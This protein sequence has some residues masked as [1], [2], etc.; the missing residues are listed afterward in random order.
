[1]NTNGLKSIFK[2]ELYHGWNKSKRFFEGWYYKLISKNGKHQLAIIVG[3]SINDKGEK[4]AFIQLLNGERLQTSY[5]TYPF[6]KFKASTKKHEVS[7]DKSTF[8]LDTLEI[9]TKYWQGKLSFFNGKEL[10][11]K[12]Y[13]PGIM[14][15]FSFFPRME[16][17]HG[18][19]QLDGEIEGKIQFKNEVFDFS[20]G[21]VYI[22]K[23][24]GHSF[25]EAYVWCQCNNFEV[26]GTFLSLS[27][28]NVKYLGIKTM[29]FFCI[30]QYQSKQ[31][32]FSTQNISKI[33][34]IRFDNNNLTI[35]IDAQKFILFLEIHE[36]NYAKLK[37][38]SKGEMLQNIKES[39]TAKVKMNLID[40]KT[41]KTIFETKGK[42]GGL[43][44]SNP[45]LLRKSYSK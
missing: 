11:S 13:A 15:I 32:K 2:P 20:K 39:L 25:P 9:N 1:M 42:Y 29:G 35:E 37:A 38:P 18:L 4:H 8:T 34:C 21:S 6:E 24:W 17:Y 5:L 12:W 26:K 16:C 22:E 7:I 23:D 40:K 45:H 30:V 44:I 3:V 33:K 41:N 10:K 28:A 14:G 31:Y 27:I 19:L 43:D 36:G